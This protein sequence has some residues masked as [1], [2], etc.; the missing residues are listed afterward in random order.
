VI[1]DEGPG[2]DVADVPSV[3]EPS[4]LESTCGRGVVLMRTLM[5]KVDFNET[6]NEVTLVKRQETKDAA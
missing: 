4:A 6:G 5:E 1:R 3:D 2:F